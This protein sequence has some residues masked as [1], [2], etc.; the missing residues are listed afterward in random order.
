M[1]EPN[2]NNLH[3]R[4]INVEEQIEKEGA[5]DLNLIQMVFTNIEK[6]FL[7]IIV[8]SII[9]LIISLYLEYSWCNNIL[10]F[11]EFNSITIVL[12]FCCWP[13]FIPYRLI[14]KCKNKNNIK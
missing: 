4:L 14:V 9:G 12:A 13:F 1:I 10:S 11:K 2:I 5:R 8:V 6:F 3:T 7:I